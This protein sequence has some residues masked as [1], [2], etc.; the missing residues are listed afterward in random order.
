VSA[1]AA[2]AAAR[3]SGRNRL[4]AGVLLVALA[5]VV[6]AEPPFT[7]PLQSAWFDA[8]QAWWPRPIVS[9]PATIVAIDRK[10]LAALGQWPSHATSPPPSASTF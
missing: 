1:A 5:L 2:W 7:R 9:M 6:W 10:S 3:R 8:C 4:V